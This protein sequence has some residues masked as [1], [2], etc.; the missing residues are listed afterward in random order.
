MLFIQESS[1]SDIKYD[2][3]RAKMFARRYVVLYT[4]HANE[5][6]L[7][8]YLIEKYSEALIPLCLKIIAKAKF[9]LNN[10]KE[11]IITIPDKRLDK[12]ASIITYGTGKVPGSA[13]LRKA[14]SSERS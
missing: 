14:L 11:L 1:Y 7:N 10:E 13:I 5:R 8:D 6:A 12:L 4:Q 3:A 2:A 9:C